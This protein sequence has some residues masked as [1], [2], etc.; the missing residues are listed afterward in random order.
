MRSV[1]HHLAEMLGDAV[2][3]GKAALRDAVRDIVKKI[4]YLLVAL[5]AFALAVGYGLHA[6]YLR[7]ALEFGPINTGF[8]FC[9][10]F[11]LIAIVCFFLMR[12]SGSGS[13]A[14][15][16]TRP[17]PPPAESA[18]PRGDDLN[19]IVFDAA[20]AYGRNVS[21]LVVVGIAA[22]AGF[23]YGRR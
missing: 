14:T 12:R 22:L 2:A 20:R 5:I 18:L 4:V 8:G 13:K 1:L 11:F 9:A 15:A 21:P 17:P 19:R 7:L 23:I 10:A 16:A 3:R 6:L